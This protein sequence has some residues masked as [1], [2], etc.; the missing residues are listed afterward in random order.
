MF[1]QISPEIFV[2]ELS[3]SWSDKK[4]IELFFVDASGF[5]EVAVI[6][7][8]IEFLLLGI[9]VSAQYPKSKGS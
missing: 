1:D 4:L 9:H 5:V 8:F 3:Y 7:Y 6:E 2:S